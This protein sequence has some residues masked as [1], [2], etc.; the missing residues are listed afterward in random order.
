[1]LSIPAGSAPSE[2]EFSCAGRVYGDL[3]SSLSD[4]TLEML[5]VIRDYIKWDGFCFELLT[6]RLTKKQLK[7]LLHR[8]WK[9]IKSDHF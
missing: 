3:R 9:I 8:I 4:A 2:R 5:V 6:E 7:F 1:L